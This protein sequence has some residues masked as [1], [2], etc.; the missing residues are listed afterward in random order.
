MVRINKVVGGQ[1][2][3]T[4]ERCV[5]WFNS[6]NSIMAYPERSLLQQASQR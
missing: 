2:S 1:Y 5:F 4:S 3:E 6:T